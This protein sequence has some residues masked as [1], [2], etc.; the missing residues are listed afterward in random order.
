[1]PSS[2]QSAAFDPSAILDNVP[3]AVMVVDRRWRHIYANAAAE[4]LLALPRSEILGKTLMEVFPDVVGTSTATSYMQAMAEQT[5][6]ELEFFYAPLATWAEIRLFPTPKTLT[7]FMRDVTARKCAEQAL[8]ETAASLAAAQRIAHI[9]SWQWDIKHDIAHWSDE[10]FRIAGIPPTALAQHR[11]KFAER[12]HPDDRGRFQQALTDAVAGVRPYNLEYRIR[13]PEGVEKIV[14]SQ[15]ELVRA[16]DGSPALIRGTVQDITERSAAEDALRESA[17]GLAEAQRIA[18]LGTWQWDFTCDRAH[19]S[20]ETFRIF[21][22]PPVGLEHHERNFM[23]LVHPEDRARVNQAL[24]DAVAGTRDYKLDYRIRSGEGAEKWIH[25]EAELARTPKGR[26]AV[27]RGTVQDVTERKRVEEQL[28]QARDFNATVL[29]T[30]DGLV[31]VLDRDARIVQ[32][33]AACERITGWKSP[34]VIGR[35]FWDILIPEEQRAGVMQA[36]AALVSGASPSRYENA[37]LTCQGE[38]RW[39]TFANAAILDKDGQVEFVIGTGIDITER[40]R[41]EASLKESQARLAALFRACPAA[42][43]ISRISD[44]MTLDVNDAIEKM[45]GYTRAE[46]IGRT[47]IELNLWKNLA[48]RKRVVESVRSTGAIWN[49]EAEFLARDH[50]PMTIVFSAVRIDYDGEPCMICSFLDI[51]QRKA[52]EENLRQSQQRFAALSVASFEGIVVSREGRILDVNDQFA[53]ILGYAP[54]ELIGREI[55]DLV[56]A[57]DQARISAHVLARREGA[58]VHGAIRHDGSRIVLEAHGKA[59]TWRGQ[60]ARITAIQDITRRQ[61]AEQDLRESEFRYRSIFENS[62][63][64]VYRVSVAGK[65]LTANP[66]LAHLFGFASPAEMVSYATDAANQ[67]YVDPRR[68]AELWDLLR[69]HGRAENFEVQARRKDGSIIWVLLNAYVVRDAAGNILY[70]EGYNTDITQRKAAEEAL[71]E[72]EARYRSIFENSSAGMCHV[73]PEGKLLAVNPAFA[74]QFGF[75]SPEEMLRHNT[76]VGRQ[77]YADPIRREE[78]WQ[79]LRAHNRVE[80]FEVEN[81]RKDG[82][83]LWLSTNAHLVRDEAGKILYCAGY[84]IDITQR[85]AAEEALRASEERFRSLI[86]F[87]PDAVVVVNSQGILYAN[88]AANRLYGVPSLVGRSPL[89]AIP[90]EQQALVAGLIQ[91][92][93]AGRPD[94]PAYRG[95]AIRADGTR[96][97]IEA[98]G[99][100]F[101]HNGAAA[102]LVI[103][104]DVSE[105]TRTHQALVDYQSRLQLLARELTV[106]QERERHELAQYLHDSVAQDLAMARLQL[107]MLKQPPFPPDAVNLLAKARELLERAIERSRA[108]TFQLSPPALYEIGL[109]AALGG[110]V[111][112]LRKLHA[113]EIEM[114]M[115]RTRL[116]LNE[117][118]SVL[119]FR[120][121]RE[122]LFNVVKHAHARHATL[123]IVESASKLTATVGD[124][125]VGF[126]ARA[127][128]ARS[129]F[130]L[131]S[132]REQLEGLG[133]I[134]TIAAKPGQGTQAT[135]VLPYN[136]GTP[137]PQESPHEDHDI[138]GR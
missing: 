5:P 97:D 39:I 87:L 122:L 130:G 13:T 4:K 16:A 68:R 28:R 7:I 47:S 57:E 40:K 73:T 107:Q 133:G 44:G 113:L 19:W 136:S 109:K 58:I 127:P 102:V 42:I 9:G 106:V 112:E 111:E 63:A 41:A 25:A 129:G 115:S 27:L 38:Q 135:I 72:S 88:P 22:M 104:R 35:P 77:L 15:G 24:A 91:N 98:A 67:L 10:T 132:I 118:Q 17:S 52:A 81:R 43:A 138:A 66:A 64:G 85:K 21:G 6:A 65:L 92:I 70:S 23:E 116:P 14:H 99:V 84:S 69:T 89:V 105:R 54:D 93:L 60:P 37:W 103:L 31:I 121:L 75:V 131:F 125:G 95:P 51:T 46:L 18:H 119:L 59:T 120:A 71:R 78:M 137:A 53:A 29:N 30:L 2:P 100:P 45:L 36:F 34:D 20:D 62:I 86:E 1:M 26:P 96:I 101:Q 80:N 134:L 126:D 55:V 128:R 49:L 117:A 124:D 11:A 12:V 74:V 32:F 82:T 3:D 83:A 50:R 8:R 56:A 76:N 90:P 33:N 114:V 79:I 94:T 48:D 123:T 61:Q 110:L 108:L